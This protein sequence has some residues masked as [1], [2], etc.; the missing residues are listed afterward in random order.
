MEVQ[1]PYYVAKLQVQACYYEVFLNEI[2]VF[3]YGVKGG[4]S[5]EIPLNTCILASGKQILKI[6]LTP[7]FNNLQL[8]NQIDLS[9]DFGYNEIV[10]EKNLGNYISL[11]KFHLPTQIKEKTLPFYEIELPFE[12]KVSWDYKNILINAQDLSGAKKLLDETVHNFYEILQKRDSQKY[13]TIIEQCLKIQTIV[14]YLSK[15]E[16][17]ELYQNASLSNIKKILPL[18]DYEMKFYVQGKLVRFQSTKRDENGNQ[19]LF[20]YTVPPLMEGKQDG[21]GAFNYLFYLPKGK[22]ELEIF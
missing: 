18:E 3:A 4:I 21:E 19:Y 11:G 15:K 10:G 16:S 20:K 12:A 9:I 6:R 8:S 2:P 13:S 1:K 5:N 7:M 17:E 22:T 14:E